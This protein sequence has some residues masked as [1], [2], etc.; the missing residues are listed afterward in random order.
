MKL[1]TA[2]FK[3][4]IQVLFFFIARLF[5]A[6]HSIEDEIIVAFLERLQLVE[7]TV[8]IECVPNQGAK[9]QIMQQNTRKQAQ[10]RQLD[11]VDAQ[12]KNGDQQ[13]YANPN[14]ELDVVERARHKQ[15]L[16]QCYVDHDRD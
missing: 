1:F 8:K 2:R 10:M 4:Q 5:V 6:I 9:G 7:Q 11:L 3:I 14:V 16:A 12:S 13:E 15:L